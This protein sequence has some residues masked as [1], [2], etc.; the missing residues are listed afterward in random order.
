MSWEGSFRNSGAI[1]G[2][3]WGGDF[4][5]EEKKAEADLTFQ[6]KMDGPC[7]GGMASITRPA[8][9]LKKSRRG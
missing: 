2:K 1:L 3:A 4:L 7:G 5:M 8:S 9:R 6:S